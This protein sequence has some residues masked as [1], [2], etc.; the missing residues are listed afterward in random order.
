MYIYVYI[1][2]K[3]IAAMLSMDLVSTLEAS[4]LIGMYGFLVMP[5]WLGLCVLR[6]N[7][8][9]RFCNPH[10]VIFTSINIIIIINIFMDLIMW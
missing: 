3:V 4:V 9:S 6:T 8:E 1:Y 7:I 2:L 5:Y 10:V